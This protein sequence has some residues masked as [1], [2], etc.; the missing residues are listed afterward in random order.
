MNAVD[1]DGFRI[2]YERAGSGPP[3]VLLR[4]FSVGKGVSEFTR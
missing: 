4:G 2:T 1:V 3:L